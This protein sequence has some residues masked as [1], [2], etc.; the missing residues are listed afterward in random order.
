MRK[1]WL[2]LLITALSYDGFSQMPSG[3]AGRQG[4]SFGGNG[5]A[6]NIGHFYGKIVD[7]AT[8]K[9][10]DGVSVQLILSKFDTVTRKRR[11]MVVSGMITGRKGDFSLE[12]LPIFG[13]YRLKITAIG[14]DTYEQKEI[15]RAS[16]RERV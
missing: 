5:Q 6:A 2:L 10:M 15:G 8:A 13:N 7:A 16:C 14:Y 4:G 1:I 9:G 12:N 11:D 3:G